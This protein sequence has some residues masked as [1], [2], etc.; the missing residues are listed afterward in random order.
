MKIKAQD[1]KYLYPK[2][3]GFWMI[4]EGKES[5]PWKW[6]CGDTVRAWRLLFQMRHRADGP[7]SC[8]VCRLCSK[9]AGEPFQSLHMICVPSVTFDPFCSIQRSQLGHLSRSGDISNFLIGPVSLM[10]VCHLTFVTEKL[11]LKAFLV[12]PSRVTR[13][14]PI[15]TET[16]V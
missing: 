16:R 2:H 6:R 4:W 1:L 10:L 14:W 7:E 9:H 5:M 12:N 3:Q 8:R 15:E 13:F 11:Y